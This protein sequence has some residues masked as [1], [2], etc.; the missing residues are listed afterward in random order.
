MDVCGGY[1][2]D[3]SIGLA[4]HYH[5]VVDILDL[6]FY[7]SFCTGDFYGITYLVI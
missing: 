5:A 2:T 3:L 1:A 4:H 7:Y 6:S